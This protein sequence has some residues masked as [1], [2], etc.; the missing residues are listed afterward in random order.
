MSDFYVYGHFD[1]DGNCCYIGKGRLRRAW[2]FCQR[3]NRWVD[4]FK[5]RKPTVVIFE[6]N[7]TEEKAYM[8]E[9][10]YISKALN[11]CYDLVNVTSG[12]NLD[13]GW[14][15]RASEILSE[16]RKGNKTWTFGIPR[17]EST[18]KKISESKRL[19]PARPWLG[20]KRDVEHMEKMSLM[21]QNEES[22]LKRYGHRKGRKLSEEHKNAI[23]KSVHKKPLTCSNGMKYESISGASK[24]LNISAGRISE[25][26]NGIRKSAK[27]LHFSF[28]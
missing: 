15:K 28:L 13:K 26:L 21:F 27:G 4:K 2:T 5:D 10:E 9:I 12:G 16:M 7:L 19:N 3:S 1:E 23:R 22:K 24:E 8:K 20:K 14:D 25:V 17:P 18:R 11:S 6:Q